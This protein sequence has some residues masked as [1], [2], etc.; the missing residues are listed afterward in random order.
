MWMVVIADKT[1]S[2]TKQKYFLVVNVLWQDLTLVFILKSSSIHIM[3]I[4]WFTESKLNF[5]LLTQF[6][7]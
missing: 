1:N 4:L 6:L 5:Y 2:E 7:L 3:T